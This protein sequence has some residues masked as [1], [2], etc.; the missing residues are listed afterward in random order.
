MPKFQPA[1]RG[2]R[3]RDGVRLLFKGMARKGNPSIPSH[4]HSPEHSHVATPHCKEGGTVQFSFQAA[5]GTAES[6]LIMENRGKRYWGASASVCHQHLLSTQNI[7]GASS[8]GVPDLDEPSG[9][10]GRQTSK[11]I[12]IVC[13]AGCLCVCCENPKAGCLSQL[14]LP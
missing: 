3:E 4:S 11:A 10:Q 12:I 2:K 14:Q 7:A 5:R 8:R 13:S 1:G 6:S 9:C